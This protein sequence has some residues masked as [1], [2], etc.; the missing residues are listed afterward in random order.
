M[1]LDHL[2]FQLVIHT[3]NLSEPADQSIIENMCPDPVH[4]DYSCSPLSQS[5]LQYVVATLYVF[6]LTRDFEATGHEHI[7]AEVLY[8]LVAIVMVMRNSH[9]R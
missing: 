8:T 9:M 5:E 1:P 7:E 3:G 4:Q 2:K 6:E